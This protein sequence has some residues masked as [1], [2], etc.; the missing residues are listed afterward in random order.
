MAENIYLL[1]GSLSPTLP[2][3]QFLIPLLGN[4]GAEYPL[5]LFSELRVETAVWQVKQRE[6]WREYSEPEYGTFQQAQ[7]WA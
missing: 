5:T 6:G 2:S 4:P 3:L 7:Q 1:P